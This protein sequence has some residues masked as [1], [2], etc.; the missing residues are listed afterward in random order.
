LLKFLQN[1]RDLEDC[2]RYIEI[3]EHAIKANVSTPKLL[4]SNQGF[5]YIKDINKTNIRLCVAEFID[6]KTLFELKEKLN[7]DEI[8]FITKQVSLINSI[9]LKPK[10]MNDEWAIINFLKEFQKKKYALSNEDLALIEPLVKKI[11][12]L[13]IEKLPHCFVHGDIIV[14]NVMK[15]S[16]NKLWIID[17]SVSNNYP[18][19][20][21]IAVLA[22][23]LFFNEDSKKESDKNL[24]IALEEYQK[25]IKLTQEELNALETYIKL[26]HAMHLLSGNFEKVKKNNDS[27]E[28]EYWINQGRKGLIQ[29]T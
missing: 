24:K 14:T 6:G 20:Q 19:I 12:K 18:R 10:F 22:C 13:E 3:M 2:K 25:K 29:T 23:N 1:F 27:E 9:G 16:N 15:D 4:K 28:N 5:L 7:E 17:F 11:K 8:K 26:A 21:E